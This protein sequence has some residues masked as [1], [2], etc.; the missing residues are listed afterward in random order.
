MEVSTNLGKKQELIIK[1]L[2]KLFYKDKIP[3]K[4]LPSL[5]SLAIQYAVL[6]KE[7][8]RKIE[9]KLLDN[10]SNMTPENVSKSCWA[11]AV[12]PR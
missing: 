9:D 8:V 10:V 7:F 11:F 1:E 3:A 5:Y 12:V 6:E 2:V 4:L